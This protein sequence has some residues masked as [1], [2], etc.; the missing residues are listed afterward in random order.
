MSILLLLFG[1]LGGCLLAVI[2]GL[3]GSRRRIG[4]G[5]A[6]L[7]SVVFSPLVGLIVTLCT[8]RLP[9]RDRK[10][11]CLGGLIGFIV[12]ALLVVLLF[13]LMPDLYEQLQAW[14]QSL[15]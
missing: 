1:L 6:F 7:L 11:G 4:F 8:P 10:W 2:V 5:W 9:N 12:A 14:I 3:V 15:R 13:V